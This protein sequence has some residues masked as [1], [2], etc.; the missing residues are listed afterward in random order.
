MASAVTQPR[1]LAPTVGQAAVLAGVFIQTG[2]VVASSGK[3]VVSGLVQRLGSLSFISDNAG[4]FGN[5]TF[6]RDGSFINFGDHQVYVTVS[7]ARVYPEKV[8]M[9][10]DPPAIRAARDRHTNGPASCV[11]VMMTAPG[12]AAGKGVASEVDAPAKATRA[13]G[14]PLERTENITDKVGT[15]AVSP[16]PT[17][18]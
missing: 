2:S 7:F 18:L 13:R 16:R 11:E 14:L 3:H 15:S 12:A 6:P 8:H 1:Q 17:L 9:A 10:A 4:Y 5:R